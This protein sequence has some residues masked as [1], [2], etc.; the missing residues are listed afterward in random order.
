MLARPQ[1]IG[2]FP[3]HH[4]KGAHEREMFVAGIFAEIRPVWA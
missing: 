1:E 3:M 2:L 4:L